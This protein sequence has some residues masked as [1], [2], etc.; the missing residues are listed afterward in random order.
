MLRAAQDVPVTSLGYCAMRYIKRLVGPALLAVALA[1][2]GAAQSKVPRFEPGDCLLN[3]DWARDVR[4][5]CG[6]LVVP[7]SRRRPDTK[8]IRLA[9]EIFRAREPNGA[10]PLVLLHGGPGGPGGIRLYSAGIAISP[11]PKHRD[12]VIY[13]QRG[14]GLSE[15][16]LCP[17]YDRVAES[18]YNLRDGAEKDSTLLSARRACIAELDAQHIDRLA[19]NTAAS[20]ADLIDLRRALGYPKWD[21]RGASYGARLAQE[22][23][24]RD[25]SGIRAVELASPV[26]R[27]FS[28]RAEQPLSTQQAFERLFAACKL[29]PPCHDAFPNVEQDFYASYD[30]L[31][32]SP[33]P[34]PITSPDGRTNTVWVDGNRLVAYI[35][36]HMLSRLEIS[37]MPLLLHELRSGDRSKATREIAGDGSVSQVLTGRVVRELVTCYDSYG[38]DYRNALGLVNGMVRPSFRRGDQRECEAWLPRFGDPSTKVPV[39]SDIP[40]L[41]VTGYFDDRTPTEQA[42]RIATTLSRV[43]LVELPNEGHDARPGPCHAAIVAQFFDD[44]TRMPDTSCVATI[45]PVRFVTTW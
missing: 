16:T 6:W 28:S 39:H 17:A 14:A 13:D 41:I 15:P 35:R 1:Q 38:P 7:E 43:Y 37:R 9:V 36:D 25:R 42:R 26:A 30:E 2:T 8:T 12:V 3:G 5:D 21:I 4:R 10:P 31:T 23:M 44:P 45:A 24:V 22:A 34:V 20:G 18:A 29:Q 19:Y 33:V 11:L 40:T 32:K 27:G